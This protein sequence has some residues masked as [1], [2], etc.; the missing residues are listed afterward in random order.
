MD[1]AS[2]LLKDLASDAKRRR[3]EWSRQRQNT[4]DLSRQA[5]VMILAEAWLF[6]TGRLPGG[7]NDPDKNPFLALVGAAWK[8]WHGA[9]AD[10]PSF[11]SQAKTAAVALQNAPSWMPPRWADINDWPGFEMIRAR[12]MSSRSVLGTTTPT[13]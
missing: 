4:G 3:D 7:S 6:A 5:F 8:D 10:V 11:F 9:G 1:R 13:K 12:L 2:S